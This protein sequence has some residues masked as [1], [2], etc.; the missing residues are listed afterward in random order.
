M[1]KM[2]SL[3]HLS[4][5]LP[6]SIWGHCSQVL[7]LLAFWGTPKGVWQW[8]FSCCFSQHLGVLGHPNTA[9]Q[10]RKQN[11]KST[12]FTPPRPP[13]RGGIAL[14]APSC[15]IR[16]RKRILSQTSIRK[17]TPQWETM[18]FGCTPKGSYGNTAFQ[19]GFWKG[20]GKGS[21]KGSEKGA[22]FYGFYSKQ[23]F[24]E[25]FSEGVLRRQFPEGA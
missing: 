18:W 14:S 17:E 2:G 23:G 15:R 25:G 21:Q 5:A 9:K 7:A 10:G 3:C 22:F 16:N 13:L 11:D 12:L 8:H 1:G 19:E 4:P 6:A 24:W 20:S